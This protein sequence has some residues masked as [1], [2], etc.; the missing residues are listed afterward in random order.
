MYDIKYLLKIS[1]IFFIVIATLTA[2]VPYVNKTPNHSEVSLTP[3]QARTQSV[4]EFSLLAEWKIGGIHDI[5]WSP[6]SKMFVVN[7]YSKNKPKNIVQAFSVES[8]RS[9]W[10][11]EDSLAEGLAFTPDGQFIFE[12]SVNF[13]AYYW[14]NIETGKVMQTHM[15]GPNDIQ[16]VDDVICHSGGQVMITNSME[17]TVVIANYSN[18]LGPRTSDIVTIR[19]LDLET[20]KCKDLFDYQGSFDLFDMNSSGMF[21]AYGG[22]GKDDSVVIWDT[23]KQTEV[24]RAPQVEFGRFVPGENILAVVRD[25]KIVFIDALT[26]QE[27]RELKT[28]PSSEYENY[29]AFSPDGKQIA[30]ARDSIEIINVSTGEILAKIPFPERAIPTSNKLLI[31]GIKFSPDGHYLLVVFYPLGSV[32]DDDIQLWQLKR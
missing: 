8:L 13:P 1:L 15:G 9:L 17:N 14:R 24:C 10:I 11:A 21:L 4:L 6:N 29:L 27:L 25:Q 30:I 32:H 5:G 3:A 19:K 18:L 31:N 12:S 28:S 22:E 7:Y 16:Q 2:C 23:Q 26:C 20:G